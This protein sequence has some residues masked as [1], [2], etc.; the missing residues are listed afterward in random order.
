MLKFAG[1]RF[2]LGSRCTDRRD[3]SGYTSAVRVDRGEDQLAPRIARPR[4]MASADRR[5]D[6]R[7]FSRFGRDS[8]STDSGRSHGRPVQKAAALS[9]PMLRQILATCDANHNGP[10]P[11]LRIARKVLSWS[12]FFAGSR[13][14]TIPAHRLPPNT[15]VGDKA[16]DPATVRRSIDYQPINLLGCRIGRP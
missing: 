6:S 2:A 16:N 3:R 4:H 15:L 9:L 12:T 7:R 13:P 14:T 11:P 8:R 10:N 1:S 5:A